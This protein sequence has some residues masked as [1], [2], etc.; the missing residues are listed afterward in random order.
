MATSS[1][2]SLPRRLD[3]RGGLHSVIN[4]SEGDRTMTTHFRYFL[5]PLGLVG[6]WFLITSLWRNPGI[7]ANST[8]LG[9]LIVIEIVVGCLWRFEKIFFLATMGCFLLAGTNLPFSVES[10]AIRWLFLAF[11]ALVGFTLWMRIDRT[12]HFGS[13]HLVALFCLFA[14]TASASASEAP[15]T[16]LLKVLSLF[17]LLLYSATG[18]RAAL[19]S[20]PGQFVGS[21]VLSC[22]LLVFGVAASYFAG[23][24]LF[25]NPNNLGAFVGVVAM[26][27]MLWSVLTAERRTQR[28]HRSVALALCGFLLYVSVCRA[29][30]VSSAVVIVGLAFGLRRPGL[31]LK[32]AF[33]AALFLEFMAVASPSHMSE[34]MDSL[35]A[36]FI[37]K[38]QSIGGRP[39]V[40]GSRE[41]PWE[42]T[43]AAVKH[44][45]WFG[46]GFGTSDLRGAGSVGPS[47]IYS[48]EGSNREHGS[49]YLAMA[50]YMGILG[51]APFLL[52]LLFLIRAATRVY[53]WMR[54]TGDVH[55]YA[56][57]FAMVVVAGLIHACFED[58]L[59]AVGS[60]LCVFFWV[61]AFLLIDLTSTNLA[62]RMAPL[63]VGTA[64]TETFQRHVHVRIV[65]M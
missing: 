12:E 34:L 3:A 57:P 53:R 5:I 23:F 20:R 45:P 28:Q 32:T 33:C 47:P 51:A 50:E 48:V 4:G 44:H 13:F 36:R 52:L 7:F 15:R 29:G 11:G 14:A 59:F 46:T 25:G 64:P 49:S 26:P 17:L 54:T 37:F 40:I 6:S 9:A 62:R 43:I 31:V 41:T 38:V 35:N 63:F 39:G 30:I 55:H 16:A 60:Y 22:E 2:D 42:D 21:I 61:S 18:A 65:D 56:V 27:I 10:F 58:W 24:D 19:V 8:F 1:T